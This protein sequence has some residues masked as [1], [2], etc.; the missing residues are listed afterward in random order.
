VEPSFPAWLFARLEMPDEIVELQLERGSTVEFDYES[1]VTLLAVFA[2]PTIQRGLFSRFLADLANGRWKILRRAMRH[3]YLCGW[4]GERSPVTQE[5]CSFASASSISRS[6]T[7][8]PN[9]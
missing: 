7:L 4:N 9:R 3:G 2:F 1:D 8:G 5:S 6:Y